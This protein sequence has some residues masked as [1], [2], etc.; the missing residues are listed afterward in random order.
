MNIKAFLDYS[1]NFT[2]KVL[3]IALNFVDDLFF[4]FLSKLGVTLPG[5][6]WL[7]PTLFVCT[8]SFT[9]I[10]WGMKRREAYVAALVT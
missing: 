3:P 6:T 8:L 1:L 4:I 5:L 7:G 10:R 2:G 9:L